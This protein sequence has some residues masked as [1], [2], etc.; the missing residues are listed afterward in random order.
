MSAAALGA[1]FFVLGTTAATALDD[2]GDSGATASRQDD[3]LGTIPPELLAVARE[4]RDLPLGARMMAVS[5][6]L[7][8][9][10]YQVDAAGEG[11]A[12]DFDPLARYDVFDCLTFVEE[13]LALT[14]PADPLAAPMV[15]NGLR[16][17]GAEPSYEARRHFMLTEWI[18]GNIEDGWLT[19]ITATLGDTHLVEVDVDA[20]TW[21]WWRKRKL[22]A[23]PD[24]ALPV[25]HFRLPVMSI[26]AAME[27][28]GDIPPGALIITVRRPKPGVPIIVTHL[29]FKVP[30]DP[31]RP[32]MRHATKM[33][34]QRVMDHSLLWYL[35]HLRWY[36]R[37]PVE[38][39]SVLMPR[40]FGPRR[41]RTLP[42][43]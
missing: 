21:R 28:A 5:D 32:V 34:G 10:P 25:G 23:L 29:G 27:V 17:G 19:D 36:D 14:L 22:F 33:K 38:G 3:P 24:A 30:S 39:I 16:Y 18:P 41:S 1:A 42:A 11:Q 6:Q 20:D 31:E 8:G 2:G 43:G 37:W 26:D 40:E 9:A 12:P 4:S 35:D 15:R 13:V 7:L